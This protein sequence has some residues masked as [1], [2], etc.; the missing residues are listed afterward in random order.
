MRSKYAA[1]V[2]SSPHRC[3]DIEI[4]VR[5]QRDKNSLLPLGSLELGWAGTSSQLVC[6]VPTLFQ[7]YLKGGAIRFRSKK[8]FPK[9][10]QRGSEP[11][12]RRMAQGRKDYPTQARA[13]KW[14]IR[15]ARRMCA[16]ME[17]TVYAI[18][19]VC[20]CILHKQAARETSTLLW[21]KEKSTNKD[22]EQ[23]EHLIGERK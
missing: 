19:C 3:K 7:E 23:S 20:L 5:A 17:N 2:R 8:Q 9:K 13:R 16:Y 12:H 4:I 14:V 15:D 18:R 21:G 1:R 11:P 6:E 10:R 22:R